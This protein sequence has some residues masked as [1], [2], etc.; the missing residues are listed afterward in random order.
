MESNI[1]M[2]IAKTFME[3]VRFILN[4]QVF[5]GI[6]IFIE[7]AMFCYG[8]LKHVM[9]SICIFL[10]QKT[11]M[12]SAKLYGIKK[13]SIESARFLNESMHILEDNTRFELIP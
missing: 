6:K 3:S 12:E 10:N 7:S 8:I 1:C 4:P 2:I 5:H 11:S 9:E 13:I